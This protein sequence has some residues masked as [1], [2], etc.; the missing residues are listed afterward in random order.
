VSYEGQ[1]AAR[2]VVN[3]ELPFFIGSVRI[4]DAAI[5][6]YPIH[7][8]FKV[9]PH[10]GL[11]EVHLHL[12][13]HPGT[14]GFPEVAHIYLGLPAF[15]WSTEDLGDPAFPARAY[16]VL[17][18]HIRRAQRCILGRP[19][20]HFE[21]IV[22]QTGELP[23]QP[24]GFMLQGGGGRDVSELLAPLVA[25]IRALTLELGR[26]GGVA[27]LPALFEFI[28]TM[29]ALG[30]DPDPGDE[31]LKLA[32]VGGPP[33]EVRRRVIGQLQAQGMSPFRV[34]WL[35][36]PAAATPSDTATG[37]PDEKPPS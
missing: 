12:D 9:S 28:K 33:D 17:K 15:S 24:G 21:P 11:K 22:W 13:P 26:P 32:L 1:D 8:L 5:D 14:H 16:P 10:A 19:I 25:P 4:K 34:T 37:S 7:N 30:R 36:P 35:G 2:W 18:E 31:L 27:H 29:R 20:G 3:L 23:L 6:L